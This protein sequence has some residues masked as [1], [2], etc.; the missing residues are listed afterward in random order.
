MQ[1]KLRTVD[2]WEDLLLLREPERTT[3]RT[4][5]HEGRLKEGPE[6]RGESGDGYSGSSTCGGEPSKE[7]KVQE[8]IESPSMDA[9][10]RTV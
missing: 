6:H 5:R 7:R 2:Y 4:H 1:H 10:N 3:Q 8:T 9:G